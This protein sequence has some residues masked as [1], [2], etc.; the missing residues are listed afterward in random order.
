MTIPG[1]H[2]LLS[3]LIYDSPVWKKHPQYLR[4]WVWFIG[5]AAFRDGHAFKGH[6]LRR[7]ELI[8]TYSEIAE[9]LSYRFN[10]AIIKPTLKE[11]RIM[12]SWLQ[13]EG[14]ISIRP[15]SDG[16]LPNKGRP[17]DLTRAYLGLLISVVNYAIYQGIESYKGMDKGRPTD[18]LGQTPKRIIRT[19]NKR[20]PSE[21]SGEISILVENLFSVPGERQLYDQLIQCLCSTRKTGKLSP[22][23][24]LRTLQ[25]FQKYPQPQVIAGI[26]TYLDKQYYQDKTK[27][28]AYLLGIIRKTKAEVQQPQQF[29]SSGSALFDKAMDAYHSGK[30]AIGEAG[31]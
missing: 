23:V 30:L 10:R 18:E 15:L 20:T 28:E 25:A 17:S 3:R 26:R 19:K 31:E 22:S 29:K 8:T 13:S 1:G 27:R 2:F 6:I 4:L 5:K 14:M 9:A 12:L 7:G 21:I 16:T 11:L 24:M